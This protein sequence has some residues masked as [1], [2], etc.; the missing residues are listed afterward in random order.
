MQKYI[1]TAPHDLS[2]KLNDHNGNEHKILPLAVT[3]VIVRNGL[4][5]FA[6]LDADYKNSATPEKIIDVLNSLKN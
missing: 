6:F 3:Y 2:L 4:V 5:K 1:N